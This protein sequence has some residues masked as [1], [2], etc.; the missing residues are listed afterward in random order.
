LQLHQVASDGDAAKL[1]RLMN[2]YVIPLYALRT[3]R[4]GYEVSVLKTMMDLLGLAGG[5]VRPPLPGLR[6]EEIVEVKTMLE[7]WRPVLA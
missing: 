1:M 2:D 4:K 3:R 5:P 6:T 7:R